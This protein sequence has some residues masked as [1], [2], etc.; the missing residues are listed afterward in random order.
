MRYTD[1]QLF[2]AQYI[3]EKQTTTLNSMGIDLSSITIP[4]LISTLASLKETDPAKLAKILVELTQTPHGKTVIN[5]LYRA[6]R[7]R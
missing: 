7:K 1:Q 2:K 3:T 4:A 5:Q 6:L